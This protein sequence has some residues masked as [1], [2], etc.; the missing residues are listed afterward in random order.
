[1][2][3]E[4][5]K[6]TLLSTL[7]AGTDSMRLKQ[8]AQEYKQVNETYEEVTKASTEAVA[9]LNSEMSRL[10]LLYENATNARNEEERKVRDALH[11]R[12][13]A[14]DLLD[15]A[16]KAHI[17]IDTV[18]S[19]IEG[20]SDPVAGQFLNLVAGM[21]LR[22]GDSTALGGHVRSVIGTVDVGAFRMW[23]GG[24]RL[25]TVASYGPYTLEIKWDS[26]RIS[27]SMRVIRVRGD[28]RHPHIS[29][30][31]H[32]CLGDATDSISREFRQGN[33][34]AGLS[35]LLGAFTNY[36]PGSTYIR[37]RSD[38]ARP[39]AGI[40]CEQCNEEGKHKCDHEHPMVPFC[41]TCLAACSQLCH[42]G[43]C[44]DCCNTHHRFS[45]AHLSKNSGL[46]NSG[47]VRKT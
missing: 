46:N 31:A 45:L 7:C 10:R 26:N 20:F 5:V 2:D 17:E 30:E 44:L 42:C 40:V 12:N 36:N 21:N 38:E 1:M 34:L 28:R 11:R 23:H 39:W 35:L 13:V 22:F 6:N 8:L 24:T 25:K 43:S 4:Q 19:A 3:L 9:E 16:T 15:T 18:K 29:Q 32:V 27:S 37:L 14:K 41:A 47:C 33:V